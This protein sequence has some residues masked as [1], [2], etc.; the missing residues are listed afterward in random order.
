MT[1]DQD[2]FD[3]LRRLLTLKRYEQPPPGYFH[4]FSQQVILRIK[5]GETGGS[6]G[7]F[8][9]WFGDS[10]W[11]NRLFGSFQPRPAFAGVAGLAMCGLMLAGIFY[12]EPEN[13]TMVATGV[14]MNALDLRP[15]PSYPHL[16][17]FPELC[18]TNG[19]LTHLLRNSVSDEV[20]R[21]VQFINSLS[22]ATF[23]SVSPATY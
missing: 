23:D 22:P 17:I 7:L 8:E 19:T 13:S 3:R 12:S 16:G 6:A 1:P 2:N 9:R 15:T 5:D 4:H 18:N 21:P 10:A 14:P 11:L 20:R